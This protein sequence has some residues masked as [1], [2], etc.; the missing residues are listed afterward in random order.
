MATSPA[1]RLWRSLEVIH[2]IVYFAPESR[3]A[4]LEAGLKGGWMGYFASRSAALG[5]VPADVVVATFYNFHPSMVR[6]ALPDA[7]KYSTPDAVISARRSAVDEALRRILGPACS[8]DDVAAAVDLA[9]RLCGGFSSAGRPLY[10]AHA[11]LEWP[12]ESHL[13]LWHAATLF[14]EHRGDGHVACLMAHAIDGCEANVLQAA[15]GSFPAESQ[16]SFRGWSAEE[17]SAAEGRLRHRGLLNHEGLT[18]EGRRTR[19]AIEDRTDELSMLSTDPLPEN[20]VE[21][22]LSHVLPTVDAILAAEVVPFPNPMGLP[23]G[24]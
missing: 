20:Q 7:W 22:L 5:Q 8:T 4:L 24:P 16:R 21:A 17:W 14:R 9:R 13:A 3:R 2:A 19:G 1:R 15:A 18:E 12:N 11:S 23:R 10:A 6:R